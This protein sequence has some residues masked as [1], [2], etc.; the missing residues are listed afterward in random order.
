M[1]TRAGILVRGRRALSYDLHGVPW[2]LLISGRALLVAVALFG[3]GTVV[4]AILLAIQ[5][6][7]G[8]LLVRLAARLPAY[9]Q[10]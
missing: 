1:V 5:A 4:N 10:L 3:F 2:R 8:L 9:V 7:P 6:V